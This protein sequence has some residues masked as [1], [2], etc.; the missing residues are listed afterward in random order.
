MSP[1]TEP[2]MVVFED[3]TAEIETA[4]EQPNPQVDAVAP[5]EEQE[6]DYSYFS[7]DIQVY[8]KTSY[9]ELTDEE[10]LTIADQAGTFEFLNDPEEDIYSPS[11]GT[12]I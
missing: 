1:I 9:P 10:I 12:P 5:Q 3:K 4:N 6:L 2:E 7:F 11:D 8:Q